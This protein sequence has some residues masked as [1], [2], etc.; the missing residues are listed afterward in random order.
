MASCKA[1]AER[2]AKEESKPIPPP[3]ASLDTKQNWLLVEEWG[4]IP[5]GTTTFQDASTCMGDPSKGIA[6]TN[7]PEAPPPGPTGQIRSNLASRP[8]VLNYLKSEGFLDWVN[9]RGL[10]CVNRIVGN[11]YG[12]NT[13]TG[14]ANRPGPSITPH[15]SQCWGTCY[16]ATTNSEICFECIKSVLIKDPKLCPEI[17]PHSPADDNLIKE[18]ISCHECV[19]S[20]AA[21]IQS[22][23]ENAQ[24]DSPDLDKMMDNIWI[25]ITGSLSN[26][27]DATDIIL[28][29]IFGVFILAA[30]L[31]LGLYFGYFHPKILRSE[32]RRRKLE[33]A[34]VNPDNY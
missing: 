21:F 31:T 27:L 16:N 22:Q 28:I 2:Y 15:D 9:R 11:F 8:P 4:C 13:T 25:C 14:Q 18:S 32:A 34:G 20:Q 30:A 3:N 26:K 6:G 29:V 17:D 23:A 7:D 10:Q 12:L 33:Q 24:P 1:L 5:P 19:G